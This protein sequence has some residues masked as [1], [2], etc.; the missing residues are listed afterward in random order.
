MP[1][2]YNSFF[3]LIYVGRHGNSSNGT[4][5]Q[6]LGHPASSSS[7]VPAPLNSWNNLPLERSKS[8]FASLTR[9]FKPWKWRVRRKSDKLESVSQCMIQPFFLC[10]PQKVNLPNYRK[11]SFKFKEKRVDVHVRFYLRNFYFVRLAIPS[12]SPL[13]TFYKRRVIGD[14]NDFLKSHNNFIFPNWLY[15]VIQECVEI[16]IY[17]TT[18]FSEF[19]GRLNIKK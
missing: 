1:C 12:R 9:L 6:S 14:N 16:Y 3:F 19:Q 4:T 15:C 18:K 8:K 13:P 17:S 5:A 10:P 2:L 11:C 7:A